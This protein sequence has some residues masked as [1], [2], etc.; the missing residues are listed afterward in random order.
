MRLVTVW[1][2]ISTLKKQRQPKKFPREFPHTDI[3]WWGPSQSRLDVRRLFTTRRQWHFC[4]FYLKYNYKNVLSHAMPCHY[5]VNQ[6]FITF[7]PSSCNIIIN[8][9]VLTNTLIK[10][11]WMIRQDFC[12]LCPRIVNIR[13]LGEKGRQKE[14]PRDSATNSLTP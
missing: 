8:G 14:Y 3:W 6:S 12:A 4:F 2:P 1:F 13:Y 9:W 5:V 7:T 11:I 10:R